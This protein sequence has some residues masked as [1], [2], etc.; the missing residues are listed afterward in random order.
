MDTFTVLAYDNNERK[1]MDVYFS[2]GERRTAEV[3][4]ST[5]GE[6]LANFILKDR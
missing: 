6:E 5:T 4:S 3:E 1:L 2:L